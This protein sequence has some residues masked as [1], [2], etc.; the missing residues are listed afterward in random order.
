MGRYF[1]FLSIKK[2]P[3]NKKVVKVEVVQKKKN[4]DFTSN[5]SEQNF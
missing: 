3:L 4:D 5:L 2:T 1:H